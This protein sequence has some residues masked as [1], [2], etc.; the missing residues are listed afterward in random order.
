MRSRPT[1]VLNEA[2]SIHEGIDEIRSGQ[3][4]SARG[5]S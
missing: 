3:S 4:A 1:G 2:L 5:R